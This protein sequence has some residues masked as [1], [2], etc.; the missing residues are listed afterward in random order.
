MAEKITS[1]TQQT[2]DGFKKIIDDQLQRANSF[3][4]ELGRLEQ[5]GIEQARAAVDEAAKLAKESLTYAAQLGAEWR[6]MAIE[7]TRRATEMM[8]FKA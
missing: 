7:A 1:Q 8:T 6:K 4:D 5:K 2:V 3:Q